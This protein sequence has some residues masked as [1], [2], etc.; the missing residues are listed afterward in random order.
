LHPKRISAGPAS[1]QALHAWR[2][3][4]P[5]TR[6][7][8][9]V[10]RRVRATSS[11][12]RARLRSNAPARDPSRPR[13]WDSPVKAGVKGSRLA[14]HH[15]GNAGRG[16]RNRHPLV[17][18]GS[19]AKAPTRVRGSAARRVCPRV[20]YGCRSRRTTPRFQ[21]TRSRRQRGAW[22]EAHSPRTRKG[23]CGFKSVDNQHR[24]GQAAA[25]GRS[26]PVAREGVTGRRPSLDGSHPGSSSRHVSFT[27]A[28]RRR[29]RR[30]TGGLVNAR[31]SRD[32]RGRRQGCQRFGPHA[33]RR[34]DNARRG[35]EHQD[36]VWSTEASRSAVEQAI[37]PAA[38][39]A[40]AHRRSREPTRR[41]CWYEE[42]N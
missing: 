42:V 8:R 9:G 2:R 14:G 41:G 6:G 20:E 15:R 18:A 32:S 17:P 5:V 28:G 11:R 34:E 39:C 23:S 21:E 25:L 10:T 31:A 37:S 16:Q 27:R 4:E 35:G 22:T 36:N 24:G 1:R 30:P 38:Q 7:A 29:S 26:K 13:K 33:P 12:A 40:Q 3:I 19:G